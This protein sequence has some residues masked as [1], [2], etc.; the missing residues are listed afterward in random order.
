MRGNNVIA[1]AEC[2][3]SFREDKITRKASAKKPNRGQGGGTI[4]LRI[5]KRLVPLPS[6]ERCRN[7]D[8][9]FGRLFSNGAGAQKSRQ[10][11]RTPK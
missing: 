2:D 7:S 4:G 6:T 8:P 9:G 3:K 1:G 10:C 11:I 5:R